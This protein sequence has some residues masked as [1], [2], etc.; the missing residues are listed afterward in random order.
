MDA[1]VCN[2][3]QMQ[4]NGLR[5]V[6]WFPIDSDPLPGRIRDA[7]TPA[8]RRMVFSH[9]GEKKMQE[10]GLNYYYIPHGVDTKKYRPMDKAES[11][12]ITKL[13]KDAYVIG[14]V[15]ANKDF[16]SRKCFVEQMS[17]FVN[18]K[19]RHPDAVMYIHTAVQSPTGVN[20]KTVMGDLQLRQGKDVF[21]ADP[22]RYVVGGY[23]EDDLAH[24]YNSF[25]VFSNVA[26]GEGF[27]IPIV[28]AQACGV[29]VIV[30][31]WTAM[32][33]LCFSGRTVKRSE[34][35]PMYS[36]LGTF[37]FI[38]HI[39]AIEALYEAEFKN[40]SSMLKARE[41]ALEYDADLVVEKYWLPVLAEIES[42]IGSSA[43]KAEEAQP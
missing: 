25:D 24:V 6:P 31:G 21:V 14:M 36:P 4:E 22:H 40:P 28:E 5:W 30:G 13:P 12:A 38:P 15:A 29:P 27:G 42:S 9:F 37:Q 41:G 16:P 23:S 7:V 1:W 8:Y 11:R 19:R 17:A 43:A 3:D 34:A 39:P 20:L 33:E 10:A 2:P 18:F 32:E 35:H 26:M